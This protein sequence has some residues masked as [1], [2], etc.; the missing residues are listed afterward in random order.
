MFLAA[1]LLVL[2]GF[3][4]KCSLVPFH[5]WTPD[6]YQGAPTPV[7][8]FFS[9]GPKAVGFAFLLRV[10]FQAF[11]FPSASMNPWACVCA[12]IAVLT[13][14]LGNIVAL[15]QDNIKRL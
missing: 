8:A 7:A 13:M 14:T 6:V 11:Q 4:F 9:V 2:V 5:M 1:F 15:K 10:L 12:A 3:G